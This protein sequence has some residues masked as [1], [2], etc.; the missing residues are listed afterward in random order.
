MRTCNRCG[1]NTAQLREDQDG[2]PEVAC[3]C[4]HREYP[5]RV[6]REFRPIEGWG[7][8]Y[9]DIASHVCQGC[10]GLKPRLK[11]GAQWHFACFIRRAIT[12][13]TQKV[14]SIDV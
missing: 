5:P 13:K 9:E 1:A 12:I 10:R 14:R 11:D 2:Q 6:K 7:M 8:P 3:L 4:G